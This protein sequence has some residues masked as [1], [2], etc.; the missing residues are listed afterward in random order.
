MRIVPAQREKLSRSTRD[1]IKLFNNSKINSVFEPNSH[2][3]MNP[4]PATS[5][6]VRPHQ[7]SNFATLNDFRTVPN[8]TSLCTASREKRSRKAPMFRSD[9]LGNKMNE[10]LNIFLSTEE[11]KN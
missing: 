3:H 1:R 11:T 4:K 2:F 9:N 10:Y 6:Q 5:Q 8:D 7:R